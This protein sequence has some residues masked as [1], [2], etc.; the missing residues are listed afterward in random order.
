MTRL[1]LLRH[2]QSEANRDIWFAGHTDAALT[3]LGRRQAQAAAAYLRANEQIDAVFSSPLRRAADTAAPTAEAFS[4]PVLPMQD[5]REI[6]AGVWEGMPFSL[7]NIRYALDRARWFN[8]LPNARCTGGETVAQVFDRVTEAV[9]HLALAHE[10]KTILLASHWTPI[11]CVMTMAQGHDVTQ[12]QKC[13]EPKNA[14]IQIIRFENGGFCPERLN[15]TE[16]LK[17]LGGGSHI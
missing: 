9:R 14:S 10:G 15:L 7:L 17:G 16:H 1:I 4:L 2:G 11:L 13:I 8:D 5:L 3:D 12:I 6:F